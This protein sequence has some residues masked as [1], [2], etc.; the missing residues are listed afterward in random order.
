MESIALSG[1]YQHIYPKIK[2]RYRKVYNLFVV[3]E[4]MI[5]RRRFFFGMLGK[6]KWIQYNKTF[7]ATMPITIWLDVVDKKIHITID[8][9]HDPAI[10]QFIYVTKIERRTNEGSIKHE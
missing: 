5:W 7:P 2:V 6:K 9:Y 3:L 4:F 1:K 10:K 8:P